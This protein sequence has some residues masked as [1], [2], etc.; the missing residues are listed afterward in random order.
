MING[1]F[2]LYLLTYVPIN[3]GQYTDALST[4]RGAVMIRSG[5]ESD[6]NET[7]G[8]VEKQ[9]PK[10]LRVGG[11]IYGVVRRQEAQ[12][13]LWQYGVLRLAV[14]NKVYSAVW[15]IPF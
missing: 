12:V 8:I 1:L 11:I 4:T 6:W 7:K 13:R 3:A 15:S 2:M 10:A 5:V 14:H 9:I